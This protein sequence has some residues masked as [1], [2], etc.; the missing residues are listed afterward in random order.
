MHGSSPGKTSTQVSTKRTRALGFAVTK[1]GRGHIVYL[2]RW[3][4]VVLLPVETIYKSLSSC[5]KPWESRFDS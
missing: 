2:F 3:L 4:P 1:R 5:R